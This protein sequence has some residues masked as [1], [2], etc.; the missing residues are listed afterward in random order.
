[1]SAAHAPV[2]GS[3]VASERPRAVA[4]TRA[5]YVVNLSYLPWFWVT[6]AAGYWVYSWF[7]L[8]PGATAITDAGIRGWLALTAWA[9]SASLPSW[10]GTR[11]AIRARRAGGGRAAAGA[12]MLNLVFI[13]GFLVLILLTG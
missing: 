4:L 6:F 9:L 7:D 3:Q 2:D 10:F 13:V 12:L 5:A 11:F 1:M 8:E